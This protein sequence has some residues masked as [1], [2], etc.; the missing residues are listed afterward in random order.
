LGYDLIDIL[1]L[2]SNH[3]HEHVYKELGGY[4]DLIRVGGYIVLP[5][6]VIESFPKGYY[7]TSR[8]WDVGNNPMTA[9]SQFLNEN[10]N[11]S[12]DEARSTKAAITESPKGYVVRVS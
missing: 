6:T 5:D 7:S 9:L 10:P 8:P 3:T 2:D 12:I 4:K 11:F 1:V